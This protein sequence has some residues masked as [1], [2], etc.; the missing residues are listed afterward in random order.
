MTALPP[1]P[2]YPGRNPRP[3][4]SLFAPALSGLE[5]LT[6]TE[7]AAS[8]AF[9]GGLAAFRAGFYWE[10]HEFWEAVWSALPQ[11]SAE[12]EL[13]RG[14]IQLANAGLKRRMGREGAVARILPLAEAALREARR[15]GGES[16]M[17]IDAA[18]LLALQV[19]IQDETAV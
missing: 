17:G 4:P 3:D 16:L 10:A 12:R 6:P 9:A 1:A 18:V 14:L 19:R 15:R 8:P 7:L 13:L 5:G 2:H 11:A